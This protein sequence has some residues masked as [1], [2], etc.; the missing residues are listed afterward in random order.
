V[1]YLKKINRR[2]KEFTNRIQKNVTEAIKRSQI[3]HCKERKGG[4]NRRLNS[5]IFGSLQY[6][7]SIVS[8]TTADRRAEK[9]SSQAAME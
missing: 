2:K 1:I 8:P 5:Q 7:P 3:A 6:V 4:F 9:K